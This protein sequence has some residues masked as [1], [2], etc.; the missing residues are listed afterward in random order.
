MERAK[1]IS[2]IETIRNVIGDTVPESK[3]KEKIILSNFDADVALDAILKESS[4]KN[5][6]GMFVTFCYGNIIDKITQNILKYIY[7]F[8]SE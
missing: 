3:L 7:R 1:L 6:V 2:C 5:A 8:N 4:P